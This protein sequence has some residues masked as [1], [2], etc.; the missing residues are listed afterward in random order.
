RSKD[1]KKQRNFKKEY[2]HDT[3]TSIAK[4]SAKAQ[5]HR[6]NKRASRT[7][8]TSRHS[9]AH[10]KT[11]SNARLP[12]DS[13]ERKVTTSPTPEP[14]SIEKI[15]ANTT[16][17]IFTNGDDPPA[18]VYLKSCKDAESF[19]SVMPLVAGVDE[20]DIR[21]ITVRF[22][23]LP[24]STPNTIRMI[25]AL[26]DSYDKM[27]EEIWKAPGWRKGGDGKA[28]VVVNVVLK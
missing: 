13:V 15:Q 16:L 6:S 2:T 3:G 4:S 5:P 10:S 11:P 22:D 20:H 28:S 17:Y 21:Q 1:G 23:W 8:S 24:E 14:V 12:S 19:F 27:M 9:A 18:T 7:P 26:P 25:R